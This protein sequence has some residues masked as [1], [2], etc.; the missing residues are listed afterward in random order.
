MIFVHVG[1][2]A[3]DLDPSSNFRDG[4]TEYVKNINFS[5]KKIYVVEANPKNLEKL[6]DCWKNYKNVK[7]FNFAI[8]PNNFS[9]DEI[10]LYYSEDDKDQD[11]YK[12]DLERC[13]TVGNVP[14][15]DSLLNNGEP[16]VIHGKVVFDPTG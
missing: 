10:D 16:S 6:K 7:I 5:E 4:F 2:G 1:A 15:E 13:Q 3:G 9:N 14:N 12:E 11:W 8:T